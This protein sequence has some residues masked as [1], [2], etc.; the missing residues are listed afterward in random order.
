MLRIHIYIYVLPFFLFQQSGGLIAEIKSQSSLYRNNST[1][2]KKKD[3]TYTYSHTHVA[4]VIVMKQNRTSFITEKS[5]FFFFICL[6]ACVVVFH[7][8]SNR[9]QHVSSQRSLTHWYRY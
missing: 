1:R 3:N 6:F 7:T 4:F 5:G 8:D 9:V 2:E